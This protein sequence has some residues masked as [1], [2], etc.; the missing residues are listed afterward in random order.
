LP[1]EN[2]VRRLKRRIDPT[3]PRVVG[4][5]LG[6]LE[7]ERI[8]VSVQDN[9]DKYGFARELGA[10]RNAVGA[11]T[12]IRLKQLDPVP[13]FVSIL[14]ELG[15][16]PALVFPYSVSAKPSLDEERHKPVDIGMGV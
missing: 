2:V 15:K 6:K 3:A 4:L 7:V 13:S 1:F 8:P 5:G 9:V 12:P 11:I 16:S 14:N 10:E